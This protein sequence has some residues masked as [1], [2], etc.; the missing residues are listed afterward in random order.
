M[1]SNLLE[2]KDK[3]TKYFRN[4]AQLKTAAM[5]DDLSFVTDLD[6]T[7]LY[8]Q[9][10]RRGTSL[11]SLHV[12]FASNITFAILYE[13]GDLVVQWDPPSYINKIKDNTHNTDCFMI[14]HISS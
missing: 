5:A 11:L 1:R 10:S 6:D 13:R 14:F 3:I 9:R 2:L 8:F 4:L 7:D 12:F